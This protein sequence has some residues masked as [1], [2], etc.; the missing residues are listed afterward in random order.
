MTLLNE[1]ALSATER[2]H[3]IGLTLPVGSLG[4][5]GPFEEKG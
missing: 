4:F 3:L 2:A 1:T 5:V